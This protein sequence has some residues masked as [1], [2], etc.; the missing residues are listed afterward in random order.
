MSSGI[1]VVIGATSRRSKSY[2]IAVPPRPD[3]R[4]RRQRFSD[5]RGHACAVG[6]HLMTMNG[7]E[8]PAEA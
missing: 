2:Y 4:S 5:R 6:G 3:S 7:S 8:G 1:G